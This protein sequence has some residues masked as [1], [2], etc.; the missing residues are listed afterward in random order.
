MGLKSWSFGSKHVVHFLVATVQ[1]PHDKPALCED[2]TDEPGQS[3]SLASVCSFG[4]A[5]HSPLLLEL[6]HE[7]YDLCISVSLSRD[8]E[9]Q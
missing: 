3:V 7:A 4:V 8:M 2:T 1:A 9:R 5:L 6:A